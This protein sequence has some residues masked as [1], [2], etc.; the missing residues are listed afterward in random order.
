MKK[1]GNYDD[2]IPMPDPQVV[3]DE[4]CRI[5]AATPGQPDFPILSKVFADVVK[6]FRVGYGAAIPIT[7]I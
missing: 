7:M 6:L 2:L 3:F 5:V 1:P 4:V